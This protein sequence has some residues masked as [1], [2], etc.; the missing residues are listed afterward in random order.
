MKKYYTSYEEVDKELEILKL[1]REINIRKIGNNAEDIVALFSP[2]TLLKQGLS[3]IGSSV[4]QSKGIKTLV[5]TTVFKFLF[6]K[7]FKK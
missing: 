2:N 3:S 5:L 4:K 6:N 1:E 7:F